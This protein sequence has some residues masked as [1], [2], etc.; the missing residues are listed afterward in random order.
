MVITMMM[1]ID[2]A[3]NQAWSMYSEWAEREYK[4]GFV[5]GYAGNVIPDETFNKV[6]IEGFGRGYEFNQMQEQLN[7]SG[8]L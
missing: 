5:A 3:M 7:N 8:V 2:K 1:N 6:F 4:A